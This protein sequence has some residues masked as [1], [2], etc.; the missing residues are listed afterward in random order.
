MHCLILANGPAPAPE[1]IQFYANQADLVIAADGGAAHALTAG[2]FP[3][4]VVGDLDSL[5]PELLDELRAAEVTIQ[6]FPPRKNETD[7]ELALAEAVRRGAA[8]LTILAA[9]G[10]RLDQTLGNLFLL[11]LPANQTVPMRLLTENEEAFV[12]RSYGHISGEPGDTVSLLPLSATA[13]GVTTLG[14]EYPLDRA[15]LA[16]GPSLG[17]SNCM[18]GA[19]AEIKV[20]EGLLLVVHTWQRP[21]Y[22]AASPANGAAS[23][24]DDPLTDEA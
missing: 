2:L 20:H 19:D 16:F 4:V 5:A 22:R 9:T 17:I 11:A 3:D 23:V 7:M 8:R 10:G 12:V 6:R 13:S 15:T 24:S 1:Q 14:L 18:L 21:P